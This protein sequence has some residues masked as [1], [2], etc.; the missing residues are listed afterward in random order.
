VS[1]TSGTIFDKTRIQLTVWFE[2]AWQMA[3]TKHGTT[4]AHLH[5]MLPVHSYPTVWAMLGRLR[6][7][8]GQTGRLLG[9]AGGVVE[10][11]ETFIGGREPGAMG[12]GAGR[13]CVVGAV[14]APDAG[15]GFGRARLRVVPDVKAPTLRAFIVENIAPGTTLRT[16]A[17]TSYPH[18]VG[19]YVHDPVNVLR[20]GKQ[21]HESLPG[22]HRLFSLVK[23]WLEG[24]Y[25]GGVQ[26]S[27]L[28]EYLDEFVFRFNRRRS[29]AR[30]MVFYRL[31]E[32]AV[33]AG[34]VTYRDLVKAPEPKAVHPAGPTSHRRPGTLAVEAADRPWRSPPA[35]EP[36][37]RPR[38]EPAAVAATP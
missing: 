14:E 4:A 2:A 6:S 8:M 35:P 1:E 16:D 17:L 27:H 36:R 21:A 31:I 30:G 26:E 38:A 20:S 7:L 34:P 24:I 22:V 5:R 32:R 37:R 29:G 13:V 11:D 9:G 25:Q 28:Q 33:A 23:R 18:A 19:G 12:R 3:T 10:I 15:K